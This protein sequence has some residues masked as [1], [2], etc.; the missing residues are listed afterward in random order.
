[1][2]LTSQWRLDPVSKGIAL[3]LVRPN[4]RLSSP[5]RLEIYNRQYWFRILDCFYDDYPGLKAIL[6]KKRF[7]R[8]AKAYLTRYPSNSF[9]LRDLGSRLVQFLEQEPHWL[10]SRRVSGLDLAKFEWAK[11]V[12]FDSERLPPLTAQRLAGADPASIKLKL[13]PYIS[14]LDLSYPFDEFSIALY[15]RER[16][17]S[18][19]GA[20]PEPD[21]R[22]GEPVALPK[23]RRTL[24]VVHRLEND[25]YYKRVEPG[26]FTLLS[27]LAVGS[28][29]AAACASA[30][31]SDPKTF[32]N[33][34][35]VAEIIQGWLK[36]FG[37]LGWFCD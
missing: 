3:E 35:V 29:L 31:S 11:I 16:E 14:L 34:D 26:A 27:K 17:R 20:P 5:E 19:A 8:L 2:P 18:E 25:L 4:S 36:A 15:R 30:I 28:S 6:G 23:R 21:D 12:A 7:L 10:G 22:G 24:V 32:C 13:Q 1:M 33:E 9:S 37:R